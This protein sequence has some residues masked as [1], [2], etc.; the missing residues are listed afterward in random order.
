MD[1]HFMSCETIQTFSMLFT[2]QAPFLLQNNGSNLMLRSCGVFNV[3][4]GILWWLFDF[5]FLNYAFSSIF[6]SE[7]MLVVNVPPFF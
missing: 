1:C 2:L 4:E 7:S 6:G 3:I 5:T